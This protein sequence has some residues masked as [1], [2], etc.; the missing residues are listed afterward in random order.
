MFAAVYFL[1]EDKYIK[2][3]FEKLTELFDDEKKNLAIAIDFMIS[4]QSHEET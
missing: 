2:A 3:S 1:G 4:Q